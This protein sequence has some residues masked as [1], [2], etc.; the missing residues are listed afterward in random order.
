MKTLLLTA[1]LSGLFT[2]AVAQEPLPSCQAVT[3]DDI[4]AMAADGIV[5]LDV[6]PITKVIGRN[7]QCTTLIDTDHGRF[8][9]IFTMVRSVN[10]ATMIRTVSQYGVSI[11]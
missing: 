8:R 2:A 7:N 1:A 11:N 3:T 5:F 9:L 6:G 4:I 10:G